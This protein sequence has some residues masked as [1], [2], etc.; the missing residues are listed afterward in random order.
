MK[1]AADTLRYAQFERPPDT[2]MG[3]AQQAEI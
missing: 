2:C 3:L 1:D